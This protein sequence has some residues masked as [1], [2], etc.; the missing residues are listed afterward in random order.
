MEKVSDLPVEKFAEMSF[1]RIIESDLYS[2]VIKSCTVK[3]PLQ[4]PFSLFFENPKG[5]R[6]VGCCPEARAIPDERWGLKG[7]EKREDKQE[8]KAGEVAQDKARKAMGAVLNEGQKIKLYARWQKQLCPF[9]R[10]WK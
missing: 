10:S 3:D 8:A 4:C 5:Q 2:S 1:E 7:E 6:W 9:L